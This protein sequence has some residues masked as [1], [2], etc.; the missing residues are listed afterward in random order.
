MNVL[1]YS[2]I[3]IFNIVIL[4]I[5]ALN[6]NQ[7]T[8]DQHSRKKLFIISI[9]SAVTANVFDIM[10]NLMMLAVLPSPVPVVL[11]VNFMYFMCFALAAYFW[12]L[13]GETLTKSDILA[14]KPKLALSFVPMI[15]LTIILIASV[16]SGKRAYFGASILNRSGKLYYAQQILAY[17]YILFISMKLLVAANNKKNYAKKD[18]YLSNAIFAVSPAIGAALQ[19]FVKNVPIASPGM[20]VS[21]LLVYIQLLKFFIAVDPL[22]GISNRR[23]ILKELEVKIA[24][25]KKG[26]KLYFLFMDIDSFKN[27]NDEYGHNEGDRELKMVAKVLSDLCRKTSGFCGR[28]G[29]DEF[30]LIQVLGEDEDISVIKKNIQESVEKRSAE[31]GLANLVNV[32]IGCAEYMADAKN[33]QDLIAYA[34]DSMYKRKKHKI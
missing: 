9:W 6:V 34:D 21:Y 2:E 30:A 24:N 17:G 13:Y 1:L 29:G 4:L 23:E 20:T 18:E 5:V 27:V 11:G 16:A 22:T 7:L 32:S 3:D 12:F 33:L 25:L 15:L 28:Y 14:N 10:R 26:E 31:E 8:N 19:L